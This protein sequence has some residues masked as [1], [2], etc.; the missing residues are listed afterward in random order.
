MKI[1]YAIRHRVLDRLSEE[2]VSLV[3]E[4]TTT[5]EASFAKPVSALDDRIAVRSQSGC[6]RAQS[7]VRRT[8]TCVELTRRIIR[9][10][11]PENREVYASWTAD[12]GIRRSGRE[13]NNFFEGNQSCGAQWGASP[14]TFGAPLS[15]LKLLIII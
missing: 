14:L 12:P 5:A 4:C 13:Y 2:I 9:A 10:L 6:E 1:L 7:A 8:T 3:L 15:T 11:P